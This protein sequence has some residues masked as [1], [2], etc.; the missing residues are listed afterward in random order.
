MSSPAL[1]P[2]ASAAVI[3][4]AGTGKTWALVARIV[5]LLLAGAAP[6]GILALTF[7]R[8]AAAEMRERVADALQKLAYASDAEVAE[9]MAEIGAPADAATLATA[10]GLFEAYCFAATPLK[11]LT[12]HSFCADLLGR[13]AMEA[14]VPAGFALA[15]DEQELRAQAVE[16]LLD[17][18]HRRQDSAESKALD[19]LLALGL[20][21]QEIRKLLDGFFEH[22]AAYWAC[23]SGVPDP[24]A[25][26]VAQLAAALDTDPAHSPTA[27]TDDAAVSAKLKMLY[28]LLKEYGD[29]RYI[30]A[31][32]LAPALDAAGDA[33]LDA[34]LAALTKK[35]DGLPFSRSGGSAHTT[36]QKEAVQ[37]HL[38]VLIEAT[39]KA[40]D[41]RLKAATLARSQ[42]ALTLGVAL[43]GEFASVQS[44]ARLLCFPELEWHSCQ[45]LTAAEGA[46]WVRYKLDARIEHL[47]LDEFQDT[48]PTQWR[49]LRPILE[50]FAAAPERSRTAFL[51]GDAKQSIYGF[52]GANAELL[53]EASDWLVEN[54]GASVS[55]FNESRR[56]APAIIHFVNALFGN[57]EGAAIGFAPH[58]AHASL[59]AVYGAVEVAPLLQSEP[60]ARPARGL[61]GVPDQ[62]RNPLTEPFKDTEETLAEREGR[63]IATR[64]QQLIED[65]MP[66]TEREQ[67]RAMRYG[68]V[69]VLARSRTHLWALEAA[70]AAQGIPFSTATRGTLLHTPLASDLL[71]LLRL[72]D[73]PHR[74]LD[75]AQALRAPIFSCSD[76]DLL[77][78]ARAANA[79]QICWLDALNQLG[80]M[81]AEL[82]RARNLLAE[83]RAL[84]AL[85]PPHDLL[86][87][88]VSE[89]DLQRRY[90]AAAPGETRIAGNLSAMLQLALDT[91]QGRYPGIS[92]FIA[93]CQRLASGEGPDEAAPA[94][95]TERVRILTVH[96]AKGLEAPAV[97]LVNSAPRPPATR[98]GWK[99]D[100]PGTAERPTLMCHVGKKE[101]QDVLSQR[102]LEAQKLR[103]AR[104]D[105]H[106]LYVAATRARQYLFVS[107][108][109]A[110]S[111]S[112]QASWHSR[113]RDAMARL[114]PE[115]PSDVSAVWG[116]DSGMPPALNSQ[117]AP[118]A[119]ALALDPALL[120]PLPD[121]AGPPPD[122]SPVDAG[123][124]LR[125]RLIHA[126]LQALAPLPGALPASTTAADWPAR[127]SRQLA[128]L[129]TAAQVEEAMAEAQAVLR[130]PAL[131]EFFN[132][133]HRAWNELA[134][135]LSDSE[136]ATEMQVL[137]RLVDNGDQLSIIDYKTRQTGSAAEMLLDATPQLHGYVAA[138]R[139]LFP[140]RHV[141]A[142][143]IATATAEWAE[144]GPQ[145]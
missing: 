91:S 140:G 67:T 124:V 120:R 134:V 104:E 48:N 22:R 3:A 2:A 44:R 94:S 79:G 74:N 25:A 31:T 102:L 49:L 143:I 54:L 51:V 139:R 30:K 20:K 78:L 61:S 88:I 108:F 106:L 29:L 56:S 6:G 127:L 95:D 65:Q 42:A 103:E 21:E 96:S 28:R 114:M 93:H 36:E 100:L 119:A 130:A 121:T 27:A 72:L 145:Q 45:L 70:L 39:L 13:F 34:L 133:R 99:V 14:R 128:A 113:C 40:R 81:S 71:A 9:Q 118:A 111:G 117:P 125:G 92:R 19:T 87:R 126:L 97:F 18:L 5:R 15:E 32:A 53:G 69:M 76:D 144:L 66:V 37:Q 7:T 115:A 8:K 83:W 135:Y 141:R 16:R 57:E 85:L 110:A 129:V 64:I 122:R 24:V 47:L 131:Q 59:G 136:G 116:F 105:Q 38:D 82:A 109:E 89:G 43:L 86:D 98:G 12:L 52:R 107:A 90:Q 50:E 80:T 137:D 73:A 84:A 138:V 68:D 60:A 46:E 1:N 75:L 123:A 101:Q 142:G 23:A 77:S 17:K 26:L 112:Q 10:R 33:R 11:A 41:A 55:Q 62:L 132:P 35:T 58:S 4:S 63:W